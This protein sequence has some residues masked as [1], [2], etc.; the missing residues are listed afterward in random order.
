MSVLEMQQQ[1]YKKK[2]EMQKQQELQKQLQLRNQQDQYQFRKNQEDIERTRLLYNQKYIKN[3]YDKINLDN[4]G[5]EDEYEDEEEDDEDNEDDEEIKNQSLNYNK[6][7]ILKTKPS[8]QDYQHFIVVSSLDR[9]WE[10]DDHNT[11]QYNFQLKFSPSGNTIINKPLYYNNPTIPA[12]FNQSSQGLRGDYNDHGWEG[13]DG[14]FYPPY[15]PDLP[16]GEIVQYEKIVEIGQKGL[17]LNNSFKNITSIELLGAMMPSVQ[18]QIE[19][20]PTLADNAI[21]E[22]YYSIEVEEIKDVMQGTSRD[23]NNS[24]AIIT[25]VIRIYDMVNSS[26]KSV[27]YKVAGMWAKRFY[28]APLSSLNNLTMTVKKPSGDIV[29]NLNDTLDV[30]YI[31][32][33]NLLDDNTNYLVIETQQYF[34]DTEYKKTDTIIFKNFIYHDSSVIGVQQFNEFM[35]RK[36]GH[37]IIITE[38]SDNTKLLK[39]RIYIARPAYLDINIGELVE[40]SW[41]TSFKNNILDITTTETILQYDLGRLINIDLQNIYFFKITTKE[42][43]IPIESE[44]V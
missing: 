7:K 6:I 16:P 38:K 43:N 41:Y 4:G 31:Y 17:S 29:K 32:Q 9:N 14:V 24:F 37:K 5:D 42:T 12:T 2:I 1:M 10:I 19:Y 25:P 34:S 11:S 21:E 23:L 28:P 39:N 20:H 8:Y 13:N 27:E 3:N 40:E 33:S 35:N 36:K 44:R 15:R 22:T 26:S 30:K 18:R